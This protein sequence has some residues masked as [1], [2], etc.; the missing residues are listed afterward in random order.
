M[1]LKRKKMYEEQRESMRG[2]RFNLERQIL[3]I[4]NATINLETIQ[5]MKHGSQAM[6]S[7]H[8]SMDVDM[9][10]ATMDDIREQMDLASEVSNAIS[11]P[12]GL[13]TVDNEEDI[14][15]EL[16]A[17][18]SSTIDEQFLSASAPVASPS[19]STAYSIPSIPASASPAQAEDEE[20]REL[21]A[22]K[23]SMNL[24]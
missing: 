24:A 9:V 10:D 14:E 16:A 8:G 15:A 17:L 19:A 20:E 3:T 23:A 2:A 22:L 1:A 5:A 18:E 11:N 12:L 7:I 21:A 6:K 13:S 4:E